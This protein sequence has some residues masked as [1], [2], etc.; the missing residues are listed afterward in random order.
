[1][2]G[3]LRHRPDA[4]Q[5]LLLVGAVLLGGALAAGLAFVT[6]A[7]TRSVDATTITSLPAA[8]LIGGGIW[9]T[10]AET[11]EVTWLMMATVERPSP[12]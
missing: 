9:A 10:T 8:A 2:V 3:D 4:S 12:S 1:M 11:G 6:A 7:L 5:P